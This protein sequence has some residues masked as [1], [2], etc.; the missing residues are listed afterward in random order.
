MSSSIIARGLPGLVRMSAEEPPLPVRLHPLVILNIT[1][2]VTR[3]QSSVHHNTVI[4]VL[5][6]LLGR[7]S[8]DGGTEIVTSYEVVISEP[9]QT[10]TTTTTSINNSNNSNE[11][12][13]SVD[14]AAVKHKRERLAEVSPELAVVGWYSVGGTSEDLVRSCSC[15]HMALCN[16][17]DD[18]SSGM[19]FALMVDCAPPA[20]L[21]TLPVHLFEATILH[22][23]KQQQQ[24][25][26]GEETGLLPR[27]NNSSSNSSNSNINTANTN[28][29]TSTSSISRITVNDTGMPGLSVG[30][31]KI[32]FLLDS[33]EITQAGMTAAMNN[34]SAGCQGS[35]VAAVAVTPQLHRIEQSLRLLKQ[36]IVLVVEY[37]KAVESGRIAD[38]D[39]E[40]L[41]LVAKICAMLPTTSAE[42]SLSY[43][44]SSTMGNNNNNNM[45]SCG[46]DIATAVEEEE[47]HSLT[48]ALLSLQTKC[49]LE[50]CKLLRMQKKTV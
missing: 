32:K 36:R 6:V 12:G 43:S 39:P 47:R 34:V 44:F 45:N 24:C 28:T 41:R 5:G 15:V 38:P 1:H 7:T 9:T 33:D 20:E 3:M 31:T 2:H 17:F 8:S 35:S 18:L 25:P 19:M 4:N 13:W 46:M 26:L 50:L 11:G 40:V 14:W 30:L 27:R 16:T 21:A 49:T 29:N 22:D 48:V 37:L 10:T 23:P 42:T